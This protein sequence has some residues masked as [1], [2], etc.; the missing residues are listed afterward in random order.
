MFS[1][2]SK[3]YPPFLEFIPICMLIFAWSYA[4]GQYANLPDVIPTHFGFNGMPDDW[5]NKGFVSVYLL[6]LIATLVYLM[7]F[8]I[9]IA[10]IKSKDP[11]KFINLPIAKDVVLDTKTLE[12][13]RTAVVRFMYAMNL[14]ITLLFAYLT[15]TTIQTG[16]GNANGVNSVLLFII[17]GALLVLTVWFT[18]KI[19]RL[20]KTSIITK[21]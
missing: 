1:D 2:F 18:V 16:L 20:Q 12:L 15:Y 14:L 7:D 4:F 10:V 6:P 17:I 13:I 5:S 8:G 11:R 3:H 19:S 9:N 21:K